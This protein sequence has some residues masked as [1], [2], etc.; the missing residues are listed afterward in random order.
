[1]WE[2]GGWRDFLD[3]PD[4]VYADIPLYCPPL[5]V[6]LKTIL[7]QPGDPDRHFLVAYQGGRPV[8]RLGVKRHRHGDYDASHFGFYESLPVGPEA[9]VALVEEARRRFPELTLRGPYNFRMEDPNTGVL[10][11]GF[12]R[13][14]YIFMGYNPPYYDEYLQ[15]AGVIPAM[16]L[17]AY[18]FRPESMRL[19]MLAAKAAAARAK[20]FTL[21][22]MNMRRVR[23]DS[24]KMADIFNDSMAENWGFEILG[25]EQVNDM[26]TLARLFLDPRLVFIAEKG[27]E[28]VGS[29]VVFPNYNPIIR[30]SRG[31]LSPRFAWEYLTQKRKLDTFRGYA[32]GVRK[33]YRDTEVSA[34][35][36]DAIL[37]QA[38]VIPWKAAEVSWVLGNNRPMNI[39]AIAAGGRRSKIYR[40]Y[41]REPLSRNLP[42]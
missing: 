36:V 5:A 39:M 1:V 42:A 6:H 27:S 13:E 17:Y 41:E 8:A 10:V 22:P 18:E 12:E 21:R 2:S 26:V 24:L 9:T 30:R 23:Q 28:A 15:A 20:G 4:R 25:E 40:I 11:E 29:V 37:Q 3:L 32:V 19:D 16:D 34:L 31:Q 14:P 7:G 38:K 35:L 33:A